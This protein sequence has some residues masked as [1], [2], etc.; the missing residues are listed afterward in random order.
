M[1]SRIR[2]VA[3]IVGTTALFGGAV[4]GC[5]SSSPSGSSSAN[6]SSTT[7]PAATAQQPAGGPRGLS[8][9]DLKTLA[10]KLGVTTTALQTAM[11]SAQPTGRPGT[12]SSSGTQADPRTQM[13]AAIAK[14]LNL[15]AAK[16]EAALSAVMPSP[17]AGS[18]GGGG[19]AP[20]TATTSS[21]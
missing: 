17:P 11:A 3:V 16:V 6:S 20:P 7:A 4:A 9:A 2:K 8:T 21:S 19:G 10:T 15:S 5:G 12:S 18:G 13:A 14:A 1:T